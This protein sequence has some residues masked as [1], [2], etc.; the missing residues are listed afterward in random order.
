MST[1]NVVHN[2]TLRLP[3]SYF[4]EGSGKRQCNLPEEFICLPNQFLLVPDGCFASVKRSL[5]HS[6]ETQRPLILE[7]YLVCFVFVDKLNYK[8]P[9]ECGSY[10]VGILPEEMGLL[11]S[12]W[13]SFTHLLSK[14]SSFHI[15]IP[16]DK[17][18][19]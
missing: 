3:L 18:Y 1:V 9:T 10:T 8:V 4:T 15:P 2:V 5:S 6:T 7:S 14:L 12:G 17:S 13:Y 16:V 19:Q 11:P